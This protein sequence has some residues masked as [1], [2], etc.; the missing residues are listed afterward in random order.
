MKR[1]FTLLLAVLMLLC[2]CA[3][4]VPKPLTQADID[5]IPIATADMTEDQLRQIVLDFF[6]LQLS[7]QWTPVEDFE[8]TIVC[9]EEDR[10]M[11]AG[12]VYAGLP[13]QGGLGNG[14]LYIAMEYYDEKTGQLSCGDMQWQD[15]TKLLG[16]QC[17]SSPA[18]AWARVVNSNKSYLATESTHANGYLIVGNYQYKTTKWT[19]HTGFT[20]DVC[21]ENGEQVMFESY[22]LVK[23]ADGLNRRCEASHTRMVAEYPVVVRNADGTINGEESYVLYMDQGSTWKEHT[24]DDGTAVLL[25]GNLS[26]KATFTDLYKKYYIPFTFAEF[27]G[28]DPVE[29][30]EAALDLPPQATVS[31]LA[32]GTLKTNYAI[33]YVKVTVT[34]EKGKQCYQITE[35]T[36][37]SDIREMFLGKIVDL[38]QISTLAEGQTLT[39]TVQVRVGTGQLLTAY[40]GTI[41]S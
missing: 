9:Y 15:L 31:Q 3:N 24:T 37:Q 6:R 7:F 41:L 35:P 25:Q 34:D 22:A 1:L 28:T 20:R 12:T 19:E 36:Y 39:M 11:K 38:S 40:E 16:N 21:K 29:P 32:T 2:G 8:Y 13:Y 30:A 18:W 23:P 33:S 5:A 14:N 17:F 27:L 4:H 10:S 26:K